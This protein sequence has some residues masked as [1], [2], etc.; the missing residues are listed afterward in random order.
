MSTPQLSIWAVLI[1]FGAVQGLVL[2]FNEIVTAVIPHQY[3]ITQMDNQSIW[4]KTE[5]RFKEENGQT[6]IRMSNSVQ[7][8][9]FWMKLMLPLM[10]GMMKKRQMGDLECLR[11]IFKEIRARN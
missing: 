8:K 3:F 4:L 1:L 5:T 9:S 6:L 11:E 10:K 2:V 7:G